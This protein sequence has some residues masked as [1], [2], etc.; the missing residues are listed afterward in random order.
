M[1]LSKEKMPFVTPTS[2]VL[3]TFTKGRAG[4]DVY[5]ESEYS[6]R[7]EAP[8]LFDTWKCGTIN[9]GNPCRKVPMGNF[10]WTGLYRVTFSNISCK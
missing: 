5:F 2:E 9:E 4:R 3:I 8:D 6:T 1:T 10:F 7:I